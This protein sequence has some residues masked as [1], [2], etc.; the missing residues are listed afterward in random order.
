MTAVWLREDQ[1]SSSPKLRS[2]GQDRTQ[3]RCNEGVCHVH[4]D[5]PVLFGVS[6]QD[7]ELSGTERRVVTRVKSTKDKLGAAR[8]MVND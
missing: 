5:W 2:R 6:N 7:A 1:Y 8:V 4:V 3:K